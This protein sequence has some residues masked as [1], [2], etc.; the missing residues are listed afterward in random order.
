MGVSDWLLK[1]AADL[2]DARLGSDFRE[3][4]QALAVRQNE[5]GFDPFGFHRD[6]LR[7]A[8]VVARF[9]HRQ[10]FRTEVFGIDNVPAGRVLLIANHSGQLPFDGLMI[11]SALLMDAK[12]PRMAR[13]MIEKFVAGMPFVSYLFARWGQITGTPE[14]CKRLLEDEEAILVFP[15]G[16]KGINKSF[17]KRYQLQDFGLGFMRLALATHTPIVPIAVIGAEEQAPAVNV[18]P[19]ARLVGAPS[20]PVMPFPP[21]VPILPLPTKYRLHFGEPME[22][23]GDPDDDDEVV[24]EKVKTVRNSIQS[25]IQL[26]LRD[27]K[28][29]FW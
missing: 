14:N 17:T 21:F 7:Y 1:R 25:M 15:E 26:G 3:T 23:E 4:T 8:A 10:Y 18:K 28:H 2:A 5:F 12:P 6:H 13:S 11:A 20:F 9:L 22:F 27:R 16:A 19:L 29:V 24:E